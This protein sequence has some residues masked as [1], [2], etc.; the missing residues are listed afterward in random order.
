[1]KPFYSIAALVELLE[2]DCFS[3]ADGLMA[4][5]AKLICNGEPANLSCW[6][7]PVITNEDGSV[8]VRTGT[9]P[10]PNPEHV[11]VSSEA[12]P[13]TI[14]ESI[15]LAEMRR[16]VQNDSPR[17][18]PHGCAGANPKALGPQAETTCLKFENGDGYAPLRVNLEG[19]WEKSFEQLPDTLKSLVKRAYFAF[20]WNSLDAANRQSIAAQH[21]YQHDPNHEPATYFELVCFCEDLKVWIEKAR[22]DSNDAKVVVLRDVADRI[23]QILDADRERVGG[24]I[25]GLRAA[26]TTQE[27][28]GKVRDTTYLNIIGALLDCIFG[29]APGAEKHPS[30]SNQSALVTLLDEKYKGF[31]G[32]SK[33]NLEKYFAEAKR[34]LKAG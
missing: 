34:N 15:K 26:R 5:G 7:R 16:A 12:L 27:T 18:T 30:F 19:C 31:S 6:H 1:M 13:S 20:P 14:V 24:E 23:E 10:V 8:I 21:D 32:L 17:H 4:C 2:D 29:E 3:V 28:S 11:V 22:Q 9:Y 25:Q 33:R